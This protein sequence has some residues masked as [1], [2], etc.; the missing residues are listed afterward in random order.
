MRVVLDANVYVSAMVNAQGNP[1]RI[2]ACWERGEF[3]VLVSAPI[4][5]EVGRVLRYPRIVKRHQQGEAAIERF[6]ALLASEA[7]VVEPSEKLEVVKEDESDNRYLEC[8]IEGRARAIVSGDG[9]LPALGE[10]GGVMIVA[11]AAFVML[12]ETGGL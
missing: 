6:L 4:I 2:M 1:Q 10:Y 5:D 12:L 3:E 11:P 8:A 9:H 7:V